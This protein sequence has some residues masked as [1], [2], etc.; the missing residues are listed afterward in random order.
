MLGGGLLSTMVK[1]SRMDDAQAELNRAARAVEAFRRELRDVEQAAD[2]RIESGG[3]LAVAD[4]LF[5]GL[6]SD[7]LMQDKIHDA[8]RKT[9]EAVRQI[10]A[11][12]RELKERIEE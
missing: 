10:R 1:H 11:V 2:I 12:R 4:F 9:E 7:W 6:L 5:D 8:Q 3:F